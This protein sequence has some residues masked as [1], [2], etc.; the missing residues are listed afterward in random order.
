MS[1]RISYLVPKEEFE[2]LLLGRKNS[3][4]Q[5]RKH[6][7]KNHP[8]VAGRQN[9][10]NALSVPRRHTKWKTAKKR[11]RSKKVKSPN[12]EKTRGNSPV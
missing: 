1:Y 4:E 2:H 9:P 3:H 8:L 11:E 5:Y 6:P 10:G 12:R 7:P